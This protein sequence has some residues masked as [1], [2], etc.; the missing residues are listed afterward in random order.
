MRLLITNLFNNFCRRRYVYI[1]FFVTLIIGGSFL[2]EKIFTSSIKNNWENIKKEKT[3]RIISEVK[4]EFN[5]Y[6]NDAASLTNQVSKRNDFINALRSFDQIALFNIL[7]EYQ[8]VE[9]G[10]DVYDSTGSLLIWTHGFISTNDFIRARTPNSYISPGSIFTLLYIQQPV[11]FNGEYLGTVVLKKLFDVNFPISNR[12]ISSDI[13]E[14]TFV[15][16]FKNPT[17]YNFAPDAKESNVARTISIP[18]TGISL[19]NLGYAYIEA[20]TLSATIEEVESNISKVRVFLLVFLTILVS[21]LIIKV[22]YNR[23]PLIYRAVATIVIL[24]IV[25]YIW[26]IAGFPADFIELKIF[27]PS[28]FASKF[29]YGLGK[30]IGEMLITAI[31]LI[32]SILCLFFDLV[33]KIQPPEERKINRWFFSN[34]LLIVYPVIFIVLFRGYIAII[35]SAVFDSTLKYID[36][37]MIFPSTELAIMLFSLFLIS[38]AFVLIGI[39][40]IIQTCRTFQWL[41]NI[42]A[43]WI[44]TLIVFFVVSYLYGTVHPNPLTTQLERLIFLTGLFIV[45]IIIEKHLSIG[46][47]TKKGY[48]VFLIVAASIFVLVSFLYLKDKEN[49]REK[50][51]AYAKDLS[52]PTDNWF[53]FI[54]DESLNQITESYK[55][56]VLK[57]DVYIGN[58]A[59]TEWA[60]SILS[61][62][63]VNCGI[64]IYNGDGKV[65]SRFE[66]G[67]VLTNNE[68]VKQIL[69][70]KRSIFIKEQKDITGTSKYYVG[71]SPLFSKDSVS[72]GGV[73]VEV[74]G[75]RGELF[76][77]ESPEIL[78][79]Y[80]RDD[81][82]SYYTNIY[83]SEFLNG[84]RVYTTN[85]EFPRQYRAPD[86]VSET[87]STT[88][89]SS[90]LVHEKIENNKYETIYIRT[91][92]NHEKWIAL[93]A[94]PVGLLR[95]LLNIL[96]LSIFT[97]AVVGMIYL[98]YITGKIIK[99]PQISFS[100]KS[101]LL[102]AFILVSLIP[103]VMA[104]YYNRQLA[105]D[106]VSELS[107]TSLENETSIVLSQLYNYID[108]GSVERLSQIDYSVCKSI[109]K[110]TGID[111]NLYDNNY[112]KESTRHELFDAELLDVRLSPEAYLNIVL[113]GK[114]FFAENQNI[115]TYPYMVGY[116]A[117]KSEEGELLGVLSVPT[118][119]KRS[120]IEEEMEKRNAYLFGVY[121]IIFLL[122]IGLGTI[123]SNQIAKPIKRLSE[124]TRRIASGD[125]DYKIKTERAD[126][127]GE[128]ES[129]FN[130]MT[131]E[132]KQRR[133]EL[134]KYEK[135]LAWKEMAK[136]VAHE[137]KNPLTPIKLAVQHLLRAYKDGAN[138]F[139]E[140][141][142]QSAQMVNEQIEA[143]SRIAT[144]FS[145]FARMPERRLVMCD[146]NEIMSEAIRLF[147][148]Y[149]NVVFKIDFFA[150][151]LYLNT[152]RDELRR[153]FINIIRNSIQAMNESGNITV[154]TRR[155]DGI[156]EISIGDSGLGIPDEIG[157]RIFEPNFSTKTEGMG[158]GLAIVKKTIDELN[159]TISFTTEKGVGTTFII[160]LP[161]LQDSNEITGGSY[162]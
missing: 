98:F 90:Y 45:G 21:Y 3:E 38:I 69:T 111:F 73:R 60:K 110:N 62:E 103:L 122:L 106:R 89:Q 150:E 135:E 53:T 81:F 24:W 66:I 83:Y 48:L 5:R 77:A 115:G 67:S 70:A 128:L 42:N 143:L 80:I 99:L 92:D 56:E 82:K 37:A 85:Q 121:S 139:N 159:G 2:L 132:I 43:R 137:I 152:D 134:I 36:P 30:S 138:N 40:L 144:E 87:F 148:Q 26:L 131:S 46:S 8:S 59:F 16:K 72:M 113:L 74:G 49:A 108:R 160:K 76:Q 126:E 27:N 68:E 7:N 102:T 123:F 153:T 15:R 118:L 129:A 78:K 161:V 114:R 151:K 145:D 86:I 25:R 125:L 11:N 58:L 154:T 130:V 120:S 91:P 109:T 146:V 57:K 29:G 107:H 41:I 50:L 95:E 63:G 104:A 23:L 51:E 88:N 6:Q 31:V 28:I 64:A 162:L 79:T 140:I 124:A 52:Q 97:M 10:F 34:L 133:E 116:R 17:K 47:V 155:I 1:V 141:M 142:N 12:F 93:N 158:L 147:E 71:Y 117:I 54:V 149:K 39:Y 61:R 84:S 157:K 4:S 136:Q 96:K 112:L 32:S 127:F 65:V 35:N 18:L 14:G 75:S 156:V 44:F 22:S 105:I 55:Q 119:F 9:T 101:K 100:F 94:E 19:N 13:F 20:P 33:K